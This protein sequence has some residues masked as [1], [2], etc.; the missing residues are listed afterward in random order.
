MSYISA[1]LRAEVV[2]RA[3]NSCEY[4]LIH[5][6]YVT[7]VHEVDHVIAQKHGGATT[8]NNLA[9]ACAQCNRNKGSD[10]ASVDPDTHE[11]VFLY[12]PRTQIW[13]NHFRFDGPLIAPLTSIG[14]ATARLL[15]LNQIDRLLLRKELL[16]T[17]RYP[18][19]FGVVD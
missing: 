1:N 10:I 11:P 9:Y 7:F 14:R 8:I 17:G 19:Q 13:T 4:C 6:D 12:N 2:A 15:Q 16:S 5:A 3:R 18:Y